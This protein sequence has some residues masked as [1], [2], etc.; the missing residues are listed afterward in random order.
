MGLFLEV[1]RG[2]KNLNLE[3]FLRQGN[4]G[5]YRLKPI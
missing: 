1:D 3:N 4:G 2:H 5:G